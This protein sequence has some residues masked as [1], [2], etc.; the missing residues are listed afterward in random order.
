[1]S[2]MSPYS[3]HLEKCIDRHCKSTNTSIKKKK[4]QSGLCPQLFSQPQEEEQWPWAWAFVLI[5]PC[6][7][8]PSSSN[9]QSLGF[10]FGW[11]QGHL[12][13][14]HQ[15]EN[16]WTLPPAKG[17]QYTSSQRKN[18]HK[19]AW[20][21]QTTLPPDWW[22]LKRSRGRRVGGGH[23]VR[24]AEV[25]DFCWPHTQLWGLRSACKTQWV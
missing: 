6:H 1:M 23:W 19:T 9:S 13:S 12:Y 15:P 2:I 22:F 21:S 18:K 17:Y 4:K 7:T 16:T 25:Q 3:Q 8:E 11:C 24:P 20:E 14:R 10:F 5:L